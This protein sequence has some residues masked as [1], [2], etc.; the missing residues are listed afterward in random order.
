[1]KRAN[2]P[3]EKTRLEHA[4]FIVDGGGKAGYYK[5]M[6]R[7]A[8]RR[9]YGRAKTPARREVKKH[10]E[11]LEAGIVLLDSNLGTLRDLDREGRKYLRGIVREHAWLLAHCEP[12]A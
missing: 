12:K 8:L 6:E 9:R 3:A 7:R 2:K 4:V 11:A 5:S 1:M 10:K